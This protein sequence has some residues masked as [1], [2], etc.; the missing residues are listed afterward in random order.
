MNRCD[1]GSAQIKPR[2]IAILCVFCCCVFPAFRTFASIPEKIQEALNLSESGD[3]EGARILLLEVIQE[4]PRHGP[5]RLLLGQMALEACDLAEAQDHLK[6]AVT[7]NP[8]RIYLAWYLLG[9]TQLQM[10]ENEAAA[11]SFSKSLES[12]PAFGPA[13]MGRAKA[14]LFLKNRES[15]EMD[16]KAAAEQQGTLWESR[17]MRAEIAIIQNEDEAARQILS[18][19][20][21]D[22]GAPSGVMTPAH[23]LLGSMDGQ[24]RFQKFL[25]E[26]WQSADAY[27]AAGVRLIRSNRKEEGIKF[28]K[29]AYDVDDQNPISALLLSQIAGGIMETPELSACRVLEKVEEAQMLARD[30]KFDSALE[31]LEG[32][33]KDRPFHVPAQ[34][35][36][37]DILEQ[38]ENYWEGLNEA[39][40]LAG[41]FP[42]FA[43]AHQRVAGIAL[44]M[45]HPDIAEC[46]AKKAIQ[47]DPSNGA[48]FF[49]QAA[50]LK[51]LG[52]TNEALE[53]C[54][55]AITSGYETASTYI[56]LGNLY[57]EE[58]KISEA[59]AALAKAIEMDPAVV[60]DVASFA[61]T[62]LTTDDFQLL[63]KTLEKHLESHPDNVTTL[64]VLGSMYLRQDRLEEAKQCFVRLEKLAPDQ[65]QIF[66]NL[67]LIYLRENRTESG[68]KAMARFHEL[69]AREQEEWEHQ[70]QA[71]RIRLRADEAFSSGK[72]EE[73]V[74]IYQELAANHT[75]ELEDAVRLADAYTGLKDNSSAISWYEKVL[76][77]F[78]YQREAIK[79]MLEA[80]RA[81]GQMDL[82][83]RFQKRLNLLSA[84][85]DH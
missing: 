41:Q 5:A 62:A 22:S 59:I 68:Q 18:G 6:I 13:L 56:L 84:G 52:K 11:D 48:L 71:H 26:Y 37:L 61:L 77:V 82:S 23:I 1:Q 38:A 36:R 35:I 64:Y 3:L 45:R 54:K 24:D 2:Y 19:I 43:L 9:R 4:E 67:G 50:A 57:Y 75:L 79:G 85:C 12:Q 53:A 29:V 80:T 15:A 66:Y 32:I 73:A 47:L 30:Q 8:H 78:P 44:R 55:K 25:S 46:S 51:D 60:E 16:L 65:S 63:Q 42:E 40:G 21:S 39:T 69:K 14:F 76:S 31:K 74:R 28:L 83:A 49:L 34:M 20:V 81:A 70:N 58:M 33:L 72:L 27:L 10:H 7:A 17:L